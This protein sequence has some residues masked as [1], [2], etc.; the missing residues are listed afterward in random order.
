MNA[1]AQSASPLD[2]GNLAASPTMTDPPDS[3]WACAARANVIE[4][5][6]PT[7]R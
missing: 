6:T 3:G 4:A 5:S 7:T 1:T 2:S